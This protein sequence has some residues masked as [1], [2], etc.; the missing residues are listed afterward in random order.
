MVVEAWGGGQRLAT[1]G[2]WEKK[3]DICNTLNDKDLKKMI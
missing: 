1:R 3:W 2:Q